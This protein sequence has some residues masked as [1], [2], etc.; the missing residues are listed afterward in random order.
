MLTLRINP[1]PDGGSRYRIELTLEKDDGTRLHESIVQ[2]HLVFTPQEQEYLR[3]YLEDFPLFPQNPAPNLAESVERSIADIGARLFKSLF[4]SEEGVH[5][6]WTALVAH[7]DNTRV[8]ITATAPEVVNIPWE[9]IRDPQTELVLGLHTQALVYTPAFPAQAARVGKLPR[10]VRTLLTICRPAGAEDLPFHVVARPLIIAMKDAPLGRFQLEVLRPPTF[11]HFEKVLGDAKAAGRPYDIV[12]FDGHGEYRP[13]LGQ[14]KKGRRGYLIFEK[15]APG[16]GNDPINGEL[17]GRTLA[18]AGVRLFIMNACRSAHA[19]P[20]LEPS[21]TGALSTTPSQAF[22]ALGHE[23]IT[24]GALGVLA[25][26]YNVYSKTAATFVTDLYIGLTQGQPLG[27]AAMGARRH[28]HSRPLP[29]PGLDQHYLQDWLVPVVY[30]RAPIALLPKFLNQ[31]PARAETNATLVESAQKRSQLVPELPDDFISSDQTLLSLDRAFDDTAVV[32]LHGLAGSGKTITAIQFAHWYQSTRGTRSIFYTSFLNCHALGHLLAE[33]KQVAEVSPKPQGT[34]WLAASETTQREPTQ[35]AL[36]QASLLWIWDDVEQIGG[37]PAGAESAWSREQQKELANFLRV[38]T[39][40]QVKIL[41]ISRRPELPW[42][43]G[44]L[45]RIKAASIRL[46]EAL[47]LA[48]ELSSRANHGAITPAAWRPLLDYAGGHPQVLSI[49]VN[50]AIKDDLRTGAQIEEFVYDL[51]C[52]EDRLGAEAASVRGSLDYGFPIEITSE[53]K[54]QVSFLYYFQGHINIDMLLA[55]G[56]LGVGGIP[57]LR[58]LTKDTALD[59]LNQLKDGGLLTSSGYGCYS[60]HPASSWY[61]KRLFDSFYSEP[62]TDDDWF[63]VLHEFSFLQSFGDSGMEVDLSPHSIPWAARWAFVKSAGWL[64]NRCHDQFYRGDRSCLSMLRAEEQNLLHALRLGK[65][66]RWWKPILPILQGLMALY[67][68]TGRSTEQEQLLENIVPNYINLKTGRPLRGREDEWSIIT[69]YRVQVAITRKQWRK[70]ERLQSMC[71]AWDRERATSRL[72]RTDD[73]LIDTR[74]ASLVNLSASLYRMA[75]ILY[76]QRN[77]QCVELVQE[78]TAISRSLSESGIEALCCRFLA[79]AFTNLDDIRDLAQAAS[80]YSQAHVL[81][82]ESDLMAR[83]ECLYGLARVAHEQFLD[84]NKEGQPEEQQ[85]VLLSAAGN[86]YE[87]ALQQTPHNMV[88]MIASAYQNLGNIR[89]TQGNVRLAI[90]NYTKA[91][92]LWEQLDDV[93]N[94]AQVRRN[95]AIALF[96]GGD[97]KTARLYAQAAA[98][99]FEHFGNARRKEPKQLER[100]IKM[101]DKQLERRATKKTV[102]LLQRALAESLLMTNRSGMALVYAHSALAHYEDL[103]E[104][105]LPE[106]HGIVSLIERVKESES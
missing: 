6:L 44:S 45:P 71:L 87:R 51:R 21:Q 89:T 23:I 15:S 98:D 92:D 80:Y 32:L 72:S 84:A 30:E 74:H 11:A 8:E 3:W 13:L 49:V 58:V 2:T 4:Q 26:R 46:P 40:S 24:A 28:L 18:L 103:G 83:S 31:E 104:E 69:D 78:A 85:A 48:S 79:R 62:D 91:I 19:D 81:F 1:T 76:E 38:I 52:G 10:R 20:V 59:L 64:G 7:I 68:Y 70:A 65:E 54:K 47:Q 66:R 95:A 99:N 12:H 90:E 102:A 55:M 86:A 73:S 56:K 9:I 16:I 75:E 5:T 106:R 101:I 17:L 35:D 88:I 34:A 100:L 36:V 33:L 43:Q 42:L 22:G 41:L 25:M 27:E 94:A 29:V 57:V 82:G 61:F 96:E 63:T 39:R 105:F 77:A 67:R 60:A 50:Q 93:L 14:P 97:A 37:F 53:Q